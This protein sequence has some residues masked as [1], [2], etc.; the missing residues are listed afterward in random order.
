MGVFFRDLPVALHLSRGLLCSRL[1]E[2]VE[3]LVRGALSHSSVSYW[4]EK[5]SYKGNDIVCLLY[6]GGIYE[7]H[8]GEK[9]VSGADMLTAP[10]AACNNILDIEIIEGCDRFGVLLD[11]NAQRYERKSMERFGRMFNTVCSQ[12]I[13]RNPNTTTV[14]DVIKKSFEDN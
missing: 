10:D 4:D 8:E 13:G 2:N 9:V 14:A 7:F 3:N 11:Y 6:Q 1:Y 5:G 12:L